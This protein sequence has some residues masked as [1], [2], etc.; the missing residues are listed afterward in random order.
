MHKG[1][2][3][4][5]LI[6]ILL[7][8]IC[9]VMGGCANEKETNSESEVK[10][11]DS[12]RFSLLEFAQR[13]QTNAYTNK[14]LTDVCYGLNDP[15]NVGVVE[16]E[17]DDV[18]YQIP[19]DEE[20]DGEIINWDTYSHTGS[21]IS[22]LKAI[23]KEVAQKNA[24]GIKVKLNMPENQVLDM[25]TSEADSYAFA[26][27]QEGLDGFYL[28][29]NNCTFNVQ[30]DDLDYRGFFYF[31]DGGDIHLQNLTVD[32]EVST[33]VTG[34]IQSYDMEN[35]SVTLKVFPECNE[36]IERIKEKEGTIYNY[37]EYSKANKIPK[38]DGTYVVNSSGTEETFDGYS[39]EGNSKDGYL[40]TV[41]FNEKAE[42]SVKGNGV[43]DYANVLFSGY[44]YNA[45]NFYDCGNVY[46]ES[47]TLHTSPSMGI[48]GYRNDNMYINGLRI[49]LK[50]GSER[51]IT[52]STDGLHIMQNDG[53][54]QITNSLIENCHDD[55]L[56]LK[57]G[58]WYDFAS[59]DVL[60]QTITIRK[61]SEGIEMPKTGDVMEIYDRDSFEKKASLTVESA[62]G[63]THAYVIKVKEPLAG[64]EM[65][66]WKKC[67]VANDSTAKLL[68]KNNIVQNKRN[69]AI[70]M[71]ASG[72]EVSNNTFQNIAHG[73]IYAW[74]VLDQY[75]ESG[76]AGDSVFKN[77][78]FINGNYENGAQAGDIYIQASAT[79]YGPSGTIQNMHVENNFFAKSGAASVTLIGVENGTVKNNFYYQSG[80][81]YEGTESVVLLY[82]ADKIE[83]SGNYCYCPEN[84]DFKGVYPGG[85]TVMEAV[86]M[87]D[88]TGL[89][90]D[91]GTSSVAADV[92]VDVPHLGKQV[93][94]IDGDVSDWTTGV[95]VDI[96]GASTEDQ[97]SASEDLYKDN[98]KIKMAKI[99]Y[100]DK[101]IYFGFDLYDNEFLFKGVEDFWYGDCVELFMTCSNEMPNA[102]MRLYKNLHE[103][104][105]LVCVPAWDSGFTLVEERTTE[106]I[107][108][109]EDKFDVAVK[110]TQEGYCGEVFIP[111]EA[112]PG[113]KEAIDNGEGLVMNCV[114][115]DGQRSNAQRVQLANV[116]HIVENNKIITGTSIRY[117]FSKSE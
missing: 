67:A 32:Y 53:V 83:L 82:N 16:E 80:R 95:D 26:I 71:M 99:A 49:S 70:I 77:N 63:T 36:W 34:I 10:E 13:M 21:D 48:V 85:T 5:K 110:E 33:T 96:V 50:E 60:K 42:G 115:A 81:V 4:K 92:K 20:F 109:Q 14:M 56:N 24:E 106:T 46:L 45:L 52:T 47:L 7:S 112:V 29:G 117:F 87:K 116:P 97:R 58:F 40:L 61:T 94:T 43:G 9:I 57:S 1:L 75:N 41:H 59:Y 54:V 78:K 93:I 90:I 89:A 68:F 86:V 107:K 100:D 17:F 69:K 103:T 101:G 51:L 25:D 30:Y 37:L 28:Q 84:V 27:V 44:N 8:I 88:N 22:K 11:E 102:D 3:Y 73:A 111:F 91:D 15:S 2:K 105:Q 38:D 74:A 6:C 39:I 72:A 65:D 108:A 76:I 12:A 23:L 35:L 66:T 104:F 18:L 79:T 113:M 19:T 62:T 31:K 98:F 55:A 64:L 114:F